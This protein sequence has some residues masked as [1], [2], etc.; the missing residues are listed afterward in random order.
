[1]AWT[2]FLKRHK[3]FIIFTVIIIISASFMLYQTFEKENTIIIPNATTDISNDY[4]GYDFGITKTVKKYRAVVFDIKSIRDYIEKNGCLKLEIKGKN[5]RMELEKQDFSRHPDFVSYTGPGDKIGSE[6]L[7]VSDNAIL[8]F[9]RTGDNDVHT[10]Y[11]ID[12]TTK[13]DEKGH[14][15]HYIYSSDDVGWSKEH[16]N[17][18]GC[19][20]SPEFLGDNITG[21]DREIYIFSENDF[22]TFPVLGRFLKFG[23]QNLEIS[24]KEAGNIQKI[25]YDKAVFYD[26]HY[27]NVNYIRS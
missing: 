5:Y 1:M 7:S 25:I 11:F 19:V 22:E 12:T 4:S 3:F 18:S 14:L 16:T 10:D 24:R 9:I 23:G 20:L 26:G 2:L 13:I 8:L 27:F 6:H 21:T 15:I 17:L